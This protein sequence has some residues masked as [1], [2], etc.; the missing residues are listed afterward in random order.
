MSVVYYLFYAKR[1]IMIGRVLIIAGSDSSGGAGIQADIKTVTALGGYS[2]TAITA[3][4]AQNT[5][6]VFGVRDIDTDFIKQQIQV[7]LEDI[8]SDCIKTGMLHTSEVIETVVAVLE[9][10]AAEKP[11]VVDPVMFAKG[12]QPLLQEPARKA[13]MQQLVP[14]ATLLTPNVK[15]AEVLCEMTICDVDALQTAGQQLLR[16]GPRAVLMKGG[17]LKSDPVIDLLVSQQGVKFFTHPR[18]Q[19]PHTHGTGCTLAS[20]IAAGLAQGLWLNAA[21]ERAYTY[22]YEAILTAPGLG[23]GRGPLNHGHTVRPFGV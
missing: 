20:A 22:L 7:V 17:H 6:G 14:K 1:S 4:T 23:K 13:L 8:G 5:Q 15:E 11:L 10:D 9:T 16:Q 18:L 3:L 21:V 19:T 12:G 2:A